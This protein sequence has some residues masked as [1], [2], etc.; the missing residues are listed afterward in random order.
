MSWNS[1]SV[2]GGLL[3]AAPALQDP[4]FERAVV[5]MC[6]H[7]DEGAMG[8]VI[9]RAA[10]LTT[11]ELMLQ[12]G[13]ECADDA[14]PTQTVLIGGPVAIESGVLLYR[15]APGTSLRDDELPVTDDLRLCPSQ[16]LL[17]AIAAGAG[18]QQFQL[19]LGH[20]GWGPGQLEQELSQGS[21][22]PARAEALLVF[23]TPLEQRWEQALAAVG[24]SPAMLGTLRPQN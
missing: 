9:N 3:V 1:A 23:E 13:F 20:A 7:N 16:E 11:L 4:N 22:I 2:A 21:W 12:M 6:L 17:R 24:V 15:A 8:L 5:L 18:P 14:D 10:P 19:F